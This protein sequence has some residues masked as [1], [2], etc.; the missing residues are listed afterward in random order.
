MV[1]GEIPV[2]WR[3]PESIQP[4]GRPPAPGSLALVQAFINSHYDLEGTHG[5]DLFAT[6]Q[7]L[8]G[9]LGEHGLIEPGAVL[10]PG[11][12]ARAIAVREGLR[13]LA[14]GL[15]VPAILHDLN[16]AAGGG[17]AEVRFDLTGPQ[18]VAH[19][20]GLNGALGLVL[21]LSAVAMIDGSW[22]RLKV[23]PGDDCG[24]AFYDLSRNQT[25]RWCSMSVCGGRAK[26]RAHYRRRRGA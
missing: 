12:R 20:D 19:A 26:A 13:A 9:W 15:R 11:D 7:A 24:W 17:S 6:P 16:T 18:F 5:A 23:C 25:G 21:A 2:Q 14:G 8:A 22:T 4:G 3:V 10:A 1:T